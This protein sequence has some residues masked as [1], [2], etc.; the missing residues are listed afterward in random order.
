MIS[1][2]EPS[3]WLFNSKQSVPKSC[4]YIYTYIIYV[5]A[6]LNILSSRLY[7]NIYAFIHICTNNYGNNYRKKYY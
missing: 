2:D 6:T 1:R 3:T 7:L 4:P 5:Y